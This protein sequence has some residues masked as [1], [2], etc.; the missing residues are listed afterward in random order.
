MLVRTAAVVCFLLVAATVPSV[1]AV[2]TE[3]L[4]QQSIASGPSMDVRYIVERDPDRIGAVNVTAVIEVPDRVTSLS[5]T[6]PANTTIESAAGMWSDDGTWR[7]NGHSE[8]ATMTYT[9]PVGVTTTFG[10]RTADTGGWSL[11]AKQDVALHGEWEWQLGPDPGWNETLALASGAEGVSGETVAYLGPA[12]TATRT[13]G[14]ETIRLV[15]PDAATLGPNRSA[16]FDTVAAARDE[17]MPTPTH[18]RVTIFVAPDRLASG[19]YTPENGEPDVIVN[20]REPVAAPT[21]VWAHEY[22]HTR[23]S[24]DATPEMAWLSEGS[25]DYYAAVATFRTGAIGYEAFRDRTT[26]RRHRTANLS[27]PDSWPSLDVEYT[28]GARA[29]ATLDARLYR[30]TG[31]ERSFVDVLIALDG[32]S[33]PVSLAAFAEVVSSVAEADLEA[34]VRRVVTGPAPP[35]PESSPVVSR[36]P[37][38][39]AGDGRANRIE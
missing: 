1:L 34:Y 8:T 20:A 9:T 30:A 32:R 28:K 16:I 36:D 7:W 26:T 2:E 25:A 6:P 12:E 11:V 33:R 27:R 13:V 24:L 21:N 38:A 19:G 35:V 10:K 31:G 29:V 22:R 17:T 3:A 14:N 39:P 18:D 4:D 37:A 23:Q 15:V 5:V